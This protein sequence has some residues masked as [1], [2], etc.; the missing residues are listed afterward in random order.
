[1]RVQVRFRSG[2]RTGQ[3]ETFDK[4]YLVVGRDPQAD[5]RFDAQRDLDVSTRHA[6]ILRSDDHVAVRD[7]GSTNGTFVN[8]R[9]ITGDV[10]LADGDVIGFGAR[11]P[12]LEVRLLGAGTPSPTGVRVAAEVA[13]Q[14]RGL[15]RTTQG[16]LAL[17][18]FAV[19]G[20]SWVQWTGAR[21]ARANAALR[22][23]ADS[24]ARATR[25]DY[26]AIA[27]TNTDAVA[28]VAVKFSNVEAVSGTAFAIDSQ[29]TLV[30][31]RHLLVG[32]DGTR[33][34]LGIA[35]KF[36]GSKQWFQARLLG[37]SRVADIGVVKVEIRGGT[38]RIAGLGAAAP[39]R[40]DPVAII[41]YPLGEDLPMERQGDAAIADPTLTVGTVSKVLHDLLQID[42]YGAPG[43]SG[44]PVFARDGRV[45]AVLY[46]GEHEARGKILYAVPGEI[47]LAYLRELGL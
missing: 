15:R 35:V 11:G 39:E 1:M 19:A 25:V 18:A 2:A 17:L 27:R 29:G 47:V 28:L 26:R 33:H 24:L 31:N 42:G 9:R 5:V 37:V 22:A 20:F 16:L 30:T 6:A 12:T 41:G 45:I 21:R 14:T 38:P 32:E 23:Q 13:R 43:S 8:G 34:P 40:G 4:G 7:L 10:A 36:S 44:S 3:E 46:G